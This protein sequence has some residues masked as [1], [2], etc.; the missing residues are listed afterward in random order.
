MSEP[1]ET[2]KH[3]SAEVADF[4]G[5]SVRPVPRSRTGGQRLSIPK[6][7]GNV[8]YQL[9]LN[10]V[11]NFHMTVPMVGQIG[12]HTQHQALRTYALVFLPVALY[13][14]QQRRKEFRSGVEWHGQHPGISHFE[15][16]SA[17][18]P[19]EW[20]YRYVDAGICFLAGYVVYHLGF[21]ALGICWM[22]GAIGFGITESLTMEAQEQ[23]LWN[24]RNQNLDAGNLSATMDSRS[25]SFAPSASRPVAGFGSGVSTGL[26]DRLARDI[27]GRGQTVEASVPQASE[28][29]PSRANDPLA[30]ITANRASKIKLAVV[31]GLAGL[32]LL[33]YNF[34]P[35][36]AVEQVKKPL[37]KVMN[38]GQDQEGTSSPSTQARPARTS[39]FRAP[40]PVQSPSP[41]QPDT[42]PLNEVAGAW[43][44]NAALSRGT[45]NSRLEVASDPAGIFT[46]FVT[47]ECRPVAPSR[48]A[49]KRHGTD[50]TPALSA[51]CLNTPYPAAAKLSGKAVGDTVELQAA[52]SFLAN[53]GGASLTAATLTPF[54]LNRLSFEFTDNSGCGGG[55]LLLN[56]IR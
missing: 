31:G 24:L 56:R 18:V 40:Q 39:I 10:G 37:R 9:L 36:R 21:T 46:A 54:G 11:A 38:R 13:Q 17:F 33:F 7:V 5:L 42:A 49:A 20:I 29:Q 15:F 23:Q 4:L 6:I 50:A 26:D 25:A 8:G 1:I 12:A 2:K 41:L 45:C 43:K 22:L 35:A 32:A 27:R 51:R 3:I 52:K 19:R 53:A 28:P 47:F 48:R 55:Q 16:L 44:G 14:R 30:A 34:T